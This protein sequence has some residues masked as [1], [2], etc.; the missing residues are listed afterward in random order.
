HAGNAD[1]LIGQAILRKAR[2]VPLDFQTD[3]ELELLLREARELALEEVPRREMERPAV[4]EVFVAE[5][6]ADAA[7]P[8]QHAKGR[9]S[10]EDDEIRRPGHLVEAH[11]AAAGERLEDARAGRIERGRRDVDV[12]AALERIDER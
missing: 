4:A 3:H 8:W 12:V 11:A 7:R 1:V 2:E 10:G 6:A 5:H 9:R